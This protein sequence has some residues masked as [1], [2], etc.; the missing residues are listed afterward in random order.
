MR[1]AGV[2]DSWN[3]FWRADVVRPCLW[4]A[5]VPAQRGERGLKM[6]A[7]AQRVLSRR[8][9]GHGRCSGIVVQTNF[10]TSSYSAANAISKNQVSILIEPLSQLPSA[11]SSV[12]TVSL[13]SP[14]QPHLQGLSLHTPYPTPVPSNTWCPFSSIPGCPPPLQGCLP[15]S[16]FVHALLCPQMP[17]P[18]PPSA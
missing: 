5:D 8:G 3:S 2:G 1:P 10:W 15:A 6:A 11:H 18:P 17:S 4:V 12:L 14:F 9:R 16:A 7:V 13:W